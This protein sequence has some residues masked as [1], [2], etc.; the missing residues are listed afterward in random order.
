MDLAL[1]R[2]EILVKVLEG[3]EDGADVI[4]AFYDNIYTVLKLLA[5]KAGAEIDKNK[6]YSF[7]HQ[8]KLRWN[9]AKRSKKTFLVFNEEWLVTRVMFLQVPV[10]HPQPLPMTSTSFDV[11][12]SEITK[13]RKTVE[14]REKYS[15]DQLTYAAQMK[16]RQEGKLTASKLIKEINFTSPLRPERIQKKLDSPTSTPLGPHEALAMMI[17]TNMSTRS[18]IYNLQKVH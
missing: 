14:L 1:T 15:S 7:K 2:R 12:Q 17:N 13:R 5:E 9:K 11:N 6:I 8:F 3:G 16:L 18:Y 10:P 4:N